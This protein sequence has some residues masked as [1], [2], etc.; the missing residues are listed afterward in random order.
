MS[1]SNR[2][3]Y[4]GSTFSAWGRAWTVV[5]RQTRAREG[6]MYVIEDA[7]GHREART[8]DT[9]LAVM[10]PQGGKMK[11]GDVVPCP[12][13]MGEIVSGDAAGLPSEYVLRG[14][15]LCRMRDIRSAEELTEFCNPD[16][17]EWAA[18]IISL[19]LGEDRRFV[20]ARRA[21]STNPR[22]V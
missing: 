16:D 13:L 14:V 1:K 10:G 20:E 8:R 11:I 18:E 22:G 3:I 19:R 21:T 5:E 12:V 6:V 17:T 7:G 4:V 2:R 15:G 9:L